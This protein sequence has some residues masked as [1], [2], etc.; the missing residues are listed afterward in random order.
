MENAKNWFKTSFFV[1]FDLFVSLQKRTTSHMLS[2]GHTC[3]HWWRSLQHP[4]LRPGQRPSNGHLAPRDLTV[5]PENKTQN[6][7][8]NRKGTLFARFGAC[9]CFAALTY[10]S[11]FCCTGFAFLEAPRASFADPLRFRVCGA[12]VSHE[13]PCLETLWSPIH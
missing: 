9:H 2:P 10:L 12:T 5:H 6:P 1:F 13:E 11:N 8:R 4:T 3:G 7:P